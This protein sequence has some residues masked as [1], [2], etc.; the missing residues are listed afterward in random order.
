MKISES[1]CLKHIHRRWTND[2]YVSLCND[3]NNMLYSNVIFIK[4]NTIQQDTIEYNIIFLLFDSSRDQ[5]PSA[6]NLLIR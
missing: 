3:K 5:Q 4:I 1:I 2:R 6:L